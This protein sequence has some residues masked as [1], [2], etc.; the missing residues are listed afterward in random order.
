MGCLSSVANTL[1][2]GLVGGGSSSPSTPPPPPAAPP[3]AT[4]A[5]L[6]NAAISEAG[7]AQNSKSRAAGI[8]G[9]GFDGT[10]STSPLGTGSA[11][12]SKQTL[13]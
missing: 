10:I 2:F 4:P 13:G 11:S 9:A 8:A 3:A 7:A 12:T 6:A 1:S 5:T